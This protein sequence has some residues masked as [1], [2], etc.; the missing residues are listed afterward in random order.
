M[1][2]KT[3]MKKALAF[4]IQII[5]Y[6]VVAMPFKVM[7][8]VPGFTDIRPVMLLW[9]VYAVFSGPSGC[10]AL[11]FGNLIMDIVSDSLRWSCIAGFI[12]N[13]IGPYLLYLY[14]S[15]VSKREFSLRNKK[16]ILTHTALIIAAAFLETLIISPAVAIVYPE[17][18]IR[19]FATTVMLNT[20]LF[21]IVLGIPL[22]IIMQEELGFKTYKK[23]KSREA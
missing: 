5:I 6:I 20:S 2:N 11:A 8:V 16:N 21:P 19:L 14:W 9:P 23:S 17:V 1:N 7:E 10:F 4:L 12:A 18:D 13:F 15:R 3:H 22:T